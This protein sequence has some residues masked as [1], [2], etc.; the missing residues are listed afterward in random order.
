MAQGDAE[1]DTGEG[2]VA[3]T[4]AKLTGH[5]QYYGISGN[6]P[7]DAAI[8]MRLRCA[9]RGN[10]SIGGVSGGSYTGSDFGLSD[11][12]TRAATA[13]HAQLYTLRL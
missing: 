5:Y 11:T 12:I 6:M 1:R 2:M 9:W 4:A 3:D 13:N 8:F 10:G 7:C